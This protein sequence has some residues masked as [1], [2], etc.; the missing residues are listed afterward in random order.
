[1]PSGHQGMGS[2]SYH[3]TLH[4]LQ[5]QMQVLNSGFGKKCF[6]INTR[7]SPTRTLNS[8]YRSGPVWTSVFSQSEANWRWLCGNPDRRHGELRHPCKLKSPCRFTFLS[9]CPCFL[10]TLH[11][12]PPRRP[13][14]R[15]RRMSVALTDAP[16][17]LGLHCHPPK[18]P[19]QIGILRTLP[20][21]SMADT[22]HGRYSVKCH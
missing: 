20:T 17:R 19:P 18:I 6:E 10:L 2:I 21:M 12:H 5:C 1:M 3:A 14:P 13:P 15:H 11:L 8:L 22:T 4:P 9:L 16:I 7:A